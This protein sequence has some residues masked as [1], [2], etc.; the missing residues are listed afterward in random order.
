MKTLASFE[1]AAYIGIDW[2]D[3][4]HDICIQPAGGVER[5][6]ECITHQPESIAQWAQ[7]IQQRFSGPIAVAL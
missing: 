6:I 5:E 1:F 4:K 7:S 2:S 3:T